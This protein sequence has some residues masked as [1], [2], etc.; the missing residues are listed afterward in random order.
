MLFNWATISNVV[1]GSERAA[2]EGRGST[3]S[4]QVHNDQA[5]PTV[6]Q[7]QANQQ[8]IEEKREHER[9]VREEAQNRADL[10]ELVD[11]VQQEK[12]QVAQNRTNLERMKADSAQHESAFNGLHGRLEVSWQHEWVVYNAVVA[13]DGPSGA[14]VVSYMNPLVGG[15]VTVYQDIKF[16]RNAAGAFYVGSAPR[17]SGTNIPA[18]FYAPDIFKLVPVGDGKWTIGEVGD[19]WDHL[20]RAV[21]R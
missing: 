20:D 9:N 14:A 3:P 17:I 1:R 10:N 13:M 12:E 2:H 5:A 6:A 16:L 19:H 8:R 21:V 18:P 4:S 15:Q 7:V 11:L